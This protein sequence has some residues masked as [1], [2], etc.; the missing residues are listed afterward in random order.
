MESIHLCMD[1]TTYLSVTGFTG[2]IQWQDSIAGGSW[3]TIAG[4]TNDSLLL[5][6]PTNSDAD[7]YYRVI[8]TNG[9]CADTSNIHN[10]FVKICCVQPGFAIMD[11][12]NPIC[13]DSTTISVQTDAI[14]GFY[15][16]QWFVVSD[17]VNPI[18]SGVD[19]DSITVGISDTIF[20]RITQNDLATC[21]IE[22]DSVITD[23]RDIATVVQCNT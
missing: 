14:A 1:D 7:K 9:T 21:F 5:W 3:N 13:G 6:F 11:P 16:Y 20:V 22:S 2:T 8:A 18:A 4:E 19:L 23:I 10:L 17:T 15:L 12:N